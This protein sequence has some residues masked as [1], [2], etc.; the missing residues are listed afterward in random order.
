MRNKA[1]SML[2]RP[3]V[4][5]K[6][7]ERTAPLIAGPNR[8]YQPVGLAL[9]LLT[10]FLV[11][12]PALHGGLLV[13]DDGN[14]TRP[15]LQPLS[16]LYRI[17]FDPTFTA[18]YYPLLHTVYWL[19]HRLWGDSVLGYH[20]VTLLWHEIAIT[21]V[22]II[23]QRIKVPGALLAAAIFALHPVM[24]ESVAWICEQK[25]T[26]STVFYLSAMLMYLDFDVSRR[27]SRYFLASGLFALALLI[28]TIT[29]TLPVSLLIIFWWQRG[30]LSWRRDVAPLVPFFVLSAALG[31][32]TVW[33][34]HTYFHGEGA[35][36]TLTL[37]QRFLLAGRAIWFYLSKLIW[38]ANL[39]FTY[40]RWTIDPNQWR[41][42][43]FPIAA[44][45][46][47][48]VLW[49]IRNRWRAP[50]AAWLFFCGTLVP[51]I[52]IANIYMFII[53]FVADHFQYLASLGV[54]V[55]FA[56]TVA[57]SLA[58]LPQYL[59]CAGAVLCVLLVVALAVLSRQQS[60]LYGNV[61]TFY[62]TALA[63]NP[64]S[65]IAYNNLGKEL[66]D[67]GNPHGAMEH[68]RAA[69]K[70]RPNFE[71]A[72]RNLAALLADDGRRSEAIQE[73]RAAL[74]LE[75]HDPQALNGL[76]LALI[77]TGHPA[78]AIQHL[79]HA[80]HSDPSYADAHN[81][82]GIA[83]GSTGKTAQAIVEFRRAL[84]LNKNSANAHNN[85]GIVLSN[86]G[87]KSQAIEHFRNALRL[88]SNDANAHFNLAANLAELGQQEEAITQFQ[89]AIR[90]RPDFADAHLE[91]AKTL[92][93]AGRSEEAIAAARRGIETVG[94]AGH[95][96]SVNQL[97]E[98]LKRYQSELERN[99]PQ[100]KPEP[101]SPA[102]SQSEKQL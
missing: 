55:L 41:Q 98:W 74:A 102:R 52:G 78:E 64:N 45:A 42:W 62:E 80:I 53:T 37:A 101:P 72:H 87:D 12:L 28:K 75:P 13:D 85:W 88:N 84:E 18:Q 21:L 47:T 92:V 95:H 19:E 8:F 89:Q 11:Y 48:F 58:R 20:L 70:I 2:R 29:V 54:F 44:L 76:G 3:K 94:S 59:R 5:A 65:W 22:Y 96:G 16:G 7:R 35:D 51:T 97:E 10:T 24:V 82:L 15:I 26:L 34:E 60:R 4:A 81:N 25:N 90:V 56:S 66:A 86:M 32:M 40:P 100:T 67:H 83:L 73:Y 36:F 49:A 61:V 63:D 23:L 9:I 77:N 39:M 99:N 69:L 1:I 57:R 33:V 91:L 17:W 30:S 71:M 14:I 6:P 27:R 68:F 50:L 38:P 46:T 93:A 43:I 79:A 31:L